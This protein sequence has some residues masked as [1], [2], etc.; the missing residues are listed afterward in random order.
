MMDGLAAPKMQPLM[1]KVV[2]TWLCVIE[3][4]T[5]EANIANEVGISFRVVQ[6][7]LYVN[8]LGNVDG[9]AAF[10]KSPMG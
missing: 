8:G 10:K 7:I 5:C 3:D 6:S 1:K 2:H 9:L 4:E